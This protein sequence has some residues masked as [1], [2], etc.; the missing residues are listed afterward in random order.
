MQASKLRMYHRISC[1]AYIYDYALS[2]REMK[3]L[4]KLHS[5]KQT[6]I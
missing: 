2:F 4:F 5:V 3:A 6:E 1:G